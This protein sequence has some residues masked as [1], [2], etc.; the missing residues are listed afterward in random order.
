M[1]I[2]NQ[3]DK[4]NAPLHS[5]KAATASKKNDK[6]TTALPTKKKA[7]GRS[8]QNQ[9]TTKQ[10]FDPGN[11]TYKDV[12][13]IAYELNTAPANAKF[14]D[15]RLV[16][17]T[18][19]GL[20]DN[21]QEDITERCQLMLDAATAAFKNKKTSTDPTVL[22]IFMVPEFA[23]RGPAGAYSM[24]QVQ[25]VINTLQTYFIGEQW[26]N[27]TFVFGTIVGQSKIDNEAL[28]SLLSQTYN[29]AANGFY[30]VYNVALLQSGGY[31][32][33][34]DAE[35]GANEVM[36]EN[37]SGIDFMVKPTSGMDWRRVDHLPPLNP[38]GLGQE[39][40]IINYDGLGIFQNNGITFGVEICLDHLTG[41]LSASPANEGQPLVQ[42]QLVP[43][44]GASI[45][46]DAV[47]AEDKGYIFNVDGNVNASSAAYEVLSKLPLASVEE[48]VV[49]SASVQVNA[50]YAGGPGK[51]RIYKSCTLPDQEY[52]TG[53]MIRLRYADGDV[54]YDF[55]LWYTQSGDQ[56]VFNRVYCTS[57][58]NNLTVMIESICLPVVN[59]SIGKRINMNANV[60]RVVNPETGTDLGVWM[61]MVLGDYHFEG[62]IITFAS[63]YEVEQ[64]RSLRKLQPSID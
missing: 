34:T 58:F 25:M 13:F 18:Y 39:H 51:I 4:G 11:V 9:S 21:L 5:K 37:M 47:V 1:E 22:K 55:T 41:R 36:K 30:E 28:D 62:V 48:D 61:N 57:Y 16:G 54:I 43:S 31:T 24:D 23:F 56:Y 45:Q 7:L 29:E 40:Q 60:V 35:K 10:V 6:K 32:D 50:L 15:G 19:L 14:I 3:V 27:W 42:V 49:P 59:G 46:A 53:K 26:A 64:K 63:N 17:G 12:Q 33:V 8:D 52:V 44:C 2:K 20:A 38:P